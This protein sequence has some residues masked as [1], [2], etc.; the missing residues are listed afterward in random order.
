MTRTGMRA[1][2]VVTL[3]FSALWQ[4]RVRTLL[5]LLGVTVGTFSLALSLAVGRGVES[6][7]LRQLRENDEL[8][9]IY[10]S[11]SFEA[12]SADVPRDTLV[13]RGVMS[14][15]RRTRLREAVVTRWNREHYTKPRAV[16]TAPQLANLAAIP[17]VRDV[18]P[19]FQERGRA[20]LNGTARPV[21]MAT[22][23]TS[24][25]GLRNRVIA[26]RLYVSPSERSVVVHEHLVYS[27]GI[28][29]EA[30]V[31]SVIGRTIRLEY[32]SGRRARY[33]VLS[34][35]TGGKVKPDAP[36]HLVL[37]DWCRACGPSS[38]AAALPR[39]NALSRA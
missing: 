16:L 22:A 17:H 30:D 27:W 35:L 15:G 4:Q 23:D 14:E 33:P 34:M 1:A 26:G 29:N 28:T 36:E 6:A 12:D 37:D 2:D 13:I 8:R 11:R 9:K 7:F 10:V 18:I 32:G 21:M 39:T 38:P 24:E 5:S 3:A 25:P 20:L 31:P 19:A